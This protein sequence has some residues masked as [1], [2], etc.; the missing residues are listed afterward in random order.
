MTDADPWE[1]RFLNILTHALPEAPPAEAFLFR[2]SLVRRVWPQAEA[3]AL[4]IAASEVLE[5]DGMSRPRILGVLRGALTAEPADLDAEFFWS[6]GH[7]DLMP[8]GEAS[9]FICC[10]VAKV[11]LPVFAA[12]TVSALA[13][14]L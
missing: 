5:E 11:A 10:R 13:C 8:L 7:G 2:R 4:I 14:R 12:I 6:S 3:E 1:R 9:P